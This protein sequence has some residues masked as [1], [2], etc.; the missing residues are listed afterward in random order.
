MHRYMFKIQDGV[1]IIEK[2]NYLKRSSML[3][4]WKMFIK[5]IQRGN[6]ERIHTAAYNFAAISPFGRC[7][8]V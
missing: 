3:K 1:G 7:E 2:L 6:P 4:S 8:R 5:K